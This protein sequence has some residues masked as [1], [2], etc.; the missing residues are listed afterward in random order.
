MFAS[1]S[2]F[3][4]EL[5]ECSKILREAGPKSFVILDGESALTQCERAADDSE[6]GRG[7]STYDGMAIA[8][9]VLHHLATHTLPLAFFAV[10]FT[11]LAS[12]RTDDQTHYGSLTD[13]YKYH[14]NIANMHMQTHVDEDRRQVV[15]LYKLIKGVAESSHGTRELMTSLFGVSAD[16]S[17]VATM[18]G[19]APEVV[20]R[21]EE[22][23][24]E[25]FAA[26]KTKL[27]GRR[28]SDLPLEALS[29]FAWL[30]R[31][32]LE[33]KKGQDEDEPMAMVDEEGEVV[34]GNWK[35]ATKSDQMNMIRRAEYVAV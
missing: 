34:K 15:F 28:K 2:T 11:S 4:V 29:D 24:K 16:C 23:S 7:T 19:V 5:D 20:S 18:A 21:A 10:S 8:G 14:P 25:F 9:S 1:A 12:V 33:A 6:L 32:A 35:K 30:I 3:K 27:A 13:D 26:F 22:I 17:D 31:T